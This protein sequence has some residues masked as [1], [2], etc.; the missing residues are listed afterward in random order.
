MLICLIFIGTIHQNVKLMM[1]YLALIGLCFIVF[2]ILY[3]KLRPSR[4]PICFIL[5]LACSLWA[6]FYII[7]GI[8]QISLIYDDI[9][10]IMPEEG[11]ELVG[12]FSQ[13]SKYMSIM[14]FFMSIVYLLGPIVI[15][16]IRIK[17]ND[18]EV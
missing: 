18:K 7:F 14:G 12:N 9:N 8:Q 2:G 1:P 13:M 17:I 6:T 11:L 10:S 15:L 3:Q 16:T 4:L 5:I